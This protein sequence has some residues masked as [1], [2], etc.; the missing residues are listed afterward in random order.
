[1]APLE[2]IDRNISPNGPTLAEI[3]RTVAGNWDDGATTE[4]EVDE[5]GDLEGAI[6][7]PRRPVS[8]RNEHHIEDREVFDV[9]EVETLRVQRRAH[10]FY[11]TG[12]H[13]GSWG[14]INSWRQPFD[15]IGERGMR[16]D[17]GR[18]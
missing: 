3:A 9:T 11:Q 10:R 4:E 6:E 18:G 17:L 7:L 12:T 8:L 15:F 1:M 16:E 2:P 14:R 13:A 5:D